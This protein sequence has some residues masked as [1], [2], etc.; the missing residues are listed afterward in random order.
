MLTEHDRKTAPSLYYAHRKRLRP[1][2]PAPS[3]TRSRDSSAERAPDLLDRN[4]IQL[5]L[6]PGQRLP[7]RTDFSPAASAPAQP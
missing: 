2:L 7:E 6:E 1:P 3:V 4:V 5:A